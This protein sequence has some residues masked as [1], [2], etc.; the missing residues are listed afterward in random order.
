MFIRSIFI[1]FGSIFINIFN[2]IR[3]IYLNSTIYNKKISKF[4]DKIVIFKPSQNILSCLIKFN[5][6]KY[7]IEN[8]SLNLVMTPD[9]IFYVIV[10]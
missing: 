3:R 5:K 6:K 1:N 9:S 4:D 10:I 7:N 8:F 2:Q